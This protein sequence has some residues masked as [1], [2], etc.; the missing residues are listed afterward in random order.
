MIAEGRRRPSLAVR[1]LE[2]DN[3]VLIAFCSSGTKKRKNY[4][5]EIKVVILYLH[6]DGGLSSGKPDDQTTGELSGRSQ[7]RKDSSFAALYRNGMAGSSKK[8][9]WRLANSG[10]T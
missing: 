4:L 2:A 9:L 10:I 7:R 3:I 5:Q 8:K 1:S 6:S